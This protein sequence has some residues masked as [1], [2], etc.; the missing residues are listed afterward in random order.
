[1]P[2]TQWRG[3]ELKVRAYVV[4]RYAW[5]TASIDVI[6]DGEPVLRTGGQL[7]FV[8]SHKS[9]FHHRGT[10]HHVELFWGKFTKG[11]F[12]FI[13]TIDDAEVLT[14]SVPVEYWKAA[15]IAWTLVILGAIGYLVACL[16]PWWQS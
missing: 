15:S 11:E 7:R 9:D 1:M 10:S 13:L 4:P 5:T 16:I 14:S 6:V 8:G 3:S 2:E 12:P